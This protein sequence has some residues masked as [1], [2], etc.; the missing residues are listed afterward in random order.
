MPLKGHSEL[1]NL[2]NQKNKQKSSKRDSP[3]DRRSRGEKGEAKRKG[4]N[5]KSGYLRNVDKDRVA[6]EIKYSLSD[7]Q[8]ISFYVPALTNIF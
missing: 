2:Q 1:K 6:S 7:S 3:T 8:L 4:K 5:Q